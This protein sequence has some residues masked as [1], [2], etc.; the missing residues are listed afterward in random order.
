MFGHC[1]EVA[2]DATKGNRASF[3]AKGP[4]DFLLNFHHPKILLGAIVVK[5]HGK[6]MHETL[7]QVLMLVQVDQQIEGVALFGA[8][9]LPIRFAGGGLAAIPVWTSWV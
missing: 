5:W 7:D 9:R 4:R 1:G 8:P 6:I 3:G 2:T